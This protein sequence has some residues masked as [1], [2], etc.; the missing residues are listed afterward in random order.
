MSCWVWTL[1]I[2]RRL[3]DWW[4]RE[5]L[6]LG[7]QWSLKVWEGVRGARFQ[8]WVKEFLVWYIQLQD[9][10]TWSCLLICC[11]WPNHFFYLGLRL[12]LKNLG[13][14]KRILAWYG[15]GS[16]GLRKA[17]L[18]TYEGI[19][20]RFKEPARLGLILLY[21][22]V[23]FLGQVVQEHALLPFEVWA[24]CFY[25]WW[26]YKRP[27]HVFMDRLIPSLMLVRVA[28]TFLRRPISWALLAVML[29]NYAFILLDRNFMISLTVLL[30]EYNTVS[31]GLFCL[32]SIHLTLFEIY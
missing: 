10:S 30:G 29:H 18:P 26:G 9:L 11:L 14:L 27:D 28:T 23:L 5:C 2:K 24:T 31:G 16:F 13:L 32:D 20:K 6:V 4:P 1:F 15:P 3:L 17:F 19:N 21:F 22:I 25:R 8:N 12:E 7:S